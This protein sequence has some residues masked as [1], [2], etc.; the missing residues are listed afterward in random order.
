MPYRFALTAC[1]L[2]VAGCLNIE[3]TRYGEDW[4]AR[5][6]AGGVE[7]FEGTYENMGEGGG[8][9]LWMFFAHEASR[10]DEAR[11]RI[12]V[13]ADGVL[14]ATLVNTKKEKAPIRLEPGT[15]YSV[16]DGTL[17]LPTD[18]GFAYHPLGSGVGTGAYSLYLTESGDLAGS[19]AGVAAGFWLNVIP[20]LG[21]GR[22]WTLWKR[23]DVP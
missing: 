10:Q 6:V 4:S 14:V 23:V 12:A 5:R 8:Y 13:E 2:L 21:I 22:D 3:G 9:E 1:A 18:E 20:I 17:W 15:G 11:V 16:R 19:A 7:A